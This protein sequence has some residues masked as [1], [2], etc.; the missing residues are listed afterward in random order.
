MSPVIL[1]S[2]LGP[3]IVYCCWL[4]CALSS[5][6]GMQAFVEAGGTFSPETSSH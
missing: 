4:L 1:G 5:A 6:D 3:L 2:I